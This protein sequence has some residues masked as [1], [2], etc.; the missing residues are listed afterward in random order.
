MSLLSLHADEGRNRTVFM[1]TG[2]PA[3]S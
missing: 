3:V 2:C 1:P